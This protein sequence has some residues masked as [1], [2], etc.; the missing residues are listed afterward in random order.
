MAH[1]P[2]AQHPGQQEPDPAGSTQ[3]FQAFVNE[4]ATSPARGGAAP[5]PQSSGPSFSTVL[6]IAAAVAI[7]AV[8]AVAWLALS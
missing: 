2:H 7:T 6:V 3:M 1:N 8:V 4:G 5:A